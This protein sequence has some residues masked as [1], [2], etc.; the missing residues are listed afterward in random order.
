MDLLP[1]KFEQ[2]MKETKVVNLSNAKLSAGLS[3]LGETVCVLQKKRKQ[4]IGRD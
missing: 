3:R 2:V 1:G 4:H